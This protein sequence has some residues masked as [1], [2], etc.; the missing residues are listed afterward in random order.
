VPSRRFRELQ[1]EFV[2]TSKRLRLA[3]TPEEKLELLN[4]LQ[5]IVKESM[6]GFGCPT[7]D[8]LFE[9]YI[10]ATT[11]Y[12][13]AAD[14][15]SNLVGLHDQFVVAKRQTEQTHAK[16]RLARLALKNHYLEHNCRVPE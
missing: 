9:H 11:E 4:E 8:A 3:H 10:R 13:V 2:E 1:D 15:L 5:R 7:A 16:C 14:D 12:F 6:I